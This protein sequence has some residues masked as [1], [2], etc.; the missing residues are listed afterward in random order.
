MDW[1]AALVITDEVFH[2]AHGRHLTSVEVAILQ[3]AWERQTYERIADAARYSP[4]YLKQDV[5][6]KLWKS[7]ATAFDE[8]VSKP[9]F[10]AIVERRFSTSV[11]PV[12]PSF[13]SVSSSTTSSETAEVST[14]PVAIPAP[15]PAET[16]HLDWGEAP[17]VSSFYG[18][19]DEIE[20]LTRWLVTEN[21][22]L[23]ALLGMGG[24]GKSTLSVKLARHVQGEF[25]TIIWRSLRNA[26]DLYTLLSELVPLLSNNQVESGSIQGLL[27][28]LRE[29]RCL[30]VLDNMESVLQAGDR[31]GSYRSGYEAYGD[32][33]QVVGESSHRSCLVLTSREKPTE[34][35]TFE[36]FGAVR[37]MTLNGSLETALALIKDKRLDGTSE[38]K[39][40]LSRLYGCCPL[41]LKIVSGSIETLF[42]GNIAAFLAEET[43]VFSGVRRLLDRQFDRLATLERSIMYWLA[44]NRDWT[45]LS[46]L[47]ADMVPPVPRGKLLEALES[48]SSRALIEHQGTRYTQQPVVMQYVADKLVQ[49]IVRE[50]QDGQPQVLVSHALTKTT[51]KEY[52][53]SA[54]VRAIVAPI[55]LELETT[56]G[57]HADID[58]K[59]RAIVDRLRE[60]ALSSGEPPARVA[61][62]Q[63]YGSSNAIALCRYLQIDT[64]NYDLSHLTVWQANLQGVNLQ[65]ANLQQADVSRCTFTQSFSSVLAIALS[66][67]GTLLAAG[68]DSGEIR[69]WQVA[70]SRSQHQY[71]SH[72][73]QPIL[74]C[75]GHDNSVRSVT[76]SPD[77]KTLISCSSDRTIR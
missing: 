59:L 40:H 71:D 57:S 54:Q 26:P 16:L 12:I 13:P 39:K 4:T 53:Y 17:D 24:M 14:T 76:F 38:Q 7:L 29:R 2:Q 73:S 45:A 25:D 62:R 11:R 58:A 49:S 61:S 23:I 55:A 66:P 31:A 64:N 15:A 52:L 30:V 77:G 69:V 28:C 56:Y 37:S 46:D 43:L 5:G 8:K 67:D 68:D 3:G 70:H 35:S 72:L 74:T 51:L 22:R 27:G 41:A 75:R 19:A 36:G 34:V 6:P 65:R 63:G 44:I 42:E 60:I 18:R 20:T 32:L 33:L 48:L 47:A 50:I 9:T 1:D 10:R 21:N